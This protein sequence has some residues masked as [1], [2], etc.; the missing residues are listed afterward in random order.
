MP[1][2]GMDGP[3][4]P[5]TSIGM[6][7]AQFAACQCQGGEELRKHSVDERVESMCIRI[8]VED[9]VRVRNGQD[10]NCQDTAFYRGTCTSISTCNQKKKRVK[11]FQSQLQVDSLKKVPVP[12]IAPHRRKL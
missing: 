6:T 8:Y 11:H 12:T 10:D 4:Y 3:G 5:K 9:D 7:S 1:D 2:G